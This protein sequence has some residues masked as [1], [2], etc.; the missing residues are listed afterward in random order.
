MAQ[1]YGVRYSAA[2]GYAAGYQARVD[3]CIS[4]KG[5]VQ[6]ALSNPAIDPAR[7]RANCVKDNGQPCGTVDP[8]FRLPT[9]DLRTSEACRP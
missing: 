5:Y 3:Q 8:N 6:Q 1:R 4:A 2:S 7:D 9:C